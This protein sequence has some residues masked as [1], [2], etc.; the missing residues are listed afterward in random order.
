[1]LCATYVSMCA[2]RFV[3]LTIT[4]F[5]LN[6]RHPVFK[7][8]SLNASATKFSYSLQLILQQKVNVVCR[9]YVGY[10]KY[11]HNFSWETQECRGEDNI[12]LICN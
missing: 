9:T 6:F 1:M 11:I 4:I 10:A 12:R 7:S 3:P 8:V 5:K 2:K